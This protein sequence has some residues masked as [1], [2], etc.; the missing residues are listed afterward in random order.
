MEQLTEALLPNPPLTR[1]MLDNMSP[2]MMRQAVKLT[3]GRVLAIKIIIFTYCFRFPWRHQV[4]STLTLL[5]PL[6]RP[7]WIVSVSVL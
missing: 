2:D 1:I 7:A 5:L 4:V 6:Q 3:A